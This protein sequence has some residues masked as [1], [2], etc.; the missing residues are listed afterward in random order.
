MNGM[1]LPAGSENCVNLLYT[2]Y[3]SSY[4]TVN[5]DGI[6]SILNAVS[7]EKPDVTIALLHWGSE[8]NDTISETQQDIAELMM[9]N[10]V[11]AIVGTH[12][13]YVQ[14]ME[15]D[16]A[17]GTFV[18]YSLGDFFGDAQRAGSEYSVVLDLE[19]TKNTDTGDTKI[20]GYSYTPIFTYTDENGPVRVLRISEA[21]AAYEAG[22]IH[23]VSQEA[24]DAMQYALTRVESR[25]AGE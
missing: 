10:G 16:E 25:I 22:Y 4:Q 7:K 3:S 20:T 18:A 21:I 6:R 17:A 1:A 8:F 14:K 24:Y 2:D 12:S 11:D 13:H 9:E 5:T 19:I 15:Y 23:R